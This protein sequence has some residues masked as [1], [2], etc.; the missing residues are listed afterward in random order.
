MISL[1]DSSPQDPTPLPDSNP[2]MSDQQ[3]PIVSDTQNNESTDTNVVRRERPARACTLRSAARLHAAAAAEAVIVAAQRKQKRKFRPPPKEAESPP[4]SPPQDKQCSKIVTQL[5]MEPEPEQLPRW[6]IRSMWEF[7]SI[8]NFLNVFR[9]ILNIKAEFSAEEF[10]TALLT[11]DSTL[12]DI[13]IPLLKGIPP[14]TRMALGRTTW[15]TVLCRK[16]RDWWH[17]VADGELPIIASQGTEIEA[18]NILPPG[19]RVVILKAL[20]DIR[21]EQEDIRNYIDN[22]IK[23]GVHISTFRKERIGGDSHGISYWYEDDPVIGQRLYREIRTVEVR[24]GKG[25]SVQPVPNSFYQWE[26]AATNVDEFQDVSEKL[27]SSK[28]RTEASLGKKLKIEMLPEVE[29]AHKTKEKLLKKQQRQALLLDNMISADGLSPGRSLRGR[30]NVSYTFDDYDKSINEA[31]N[32]TKKQSP[33]DSTVRREGTRSYISTN[34]ELG[35]PS[36]VPEHS[37]SMLTPESHDEN[38]EDLTYETLGRGSRRRQRPERY[39]AKEFVEEMSDNDA[40][41]D[42]DDEIVG[43]AVYD[44]EYLKKRKETRIMS[45]GSEGDEEYQWEGENVEEEEE[46]DEYSL[47]MGD[48]SDECIS[49][50]S[51]KR[52]KPKK[53]QGRTRRESK[54]RSVN[55]FDSGL[56][57]SNRA[58]RNRID[59]RKLEVSDSETESL[60]PEKSNASDEHTDASEKDDFSINSES[61]ESDASDIQYR[62]IDS[63]P[64]EQP[65]ASDEQPEASDEEQPVPMQED[66]S[67]AIYGNQQEVVYEDPSERMYESQPEGAY[68]NHSEGAYGNQ[69]ASVYHQ[70]SE[71]AYG[72][73]SASVYQQESE[74]AYGNQSEAVHVNQQAAAEED[75]VQFPI[76]ADSP[77]QDKAEVQRRG[78]LDLNELAPGSGFDDG[79]DSMMKGEDTDNF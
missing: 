67:E 34:G 29:K 16:L 57:R 75:Q 6:S 33:P 49:D 71:G 5:V 47:S 39:P 52:Q 7:A 35:G 26:T 8:L 20:C 12:A 1:C 65:E 9:P 38:D 17:W 55:E 44:D 68:G 51:G 40:E 19:V 22:S 13:H 2:T 18:Y 24:K 59:Y 50:D 15:I 25:K 32:V 61:E 58:T 21:V 36:Q 14:V 54:L 53:L 23:Q 76:K 42:S 28:N 43:E 66:Q 78:F 11:P 41:F 4:P 63:P 27:F 70:Q 48:D 30:K 64:E 45:S 37:F 72:N 69:S 56:R 10:E 79:P 46:E 74:G 77:V 3:I 60:K 31:I 62:D 73:H